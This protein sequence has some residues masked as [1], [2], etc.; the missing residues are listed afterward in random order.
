MFGLSHTRHRQTPQ[1]EINSPLPRLTGIPIP[2]AGEWILRQARSVSD[3]PVSRIVEIG[4]FG[5]KDKAQNASQYV[6]FRGG[7]ATLRR[8]HRRGRARKAERL[9]FAKI[10]VFPVIA[11]GRPEIF[12]GNGAGRGSEAHT[13]AEEGVVVEDGVGGVEAAE[14]GGQLDG[15]AAVVG[16]SG[17]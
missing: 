12:L 7:R 13:D 3:C 16:A 14:G 1:S 9:I 8:N 15:G 4:D 5:M 17:Q 11:S 10:A 2:L 6:W